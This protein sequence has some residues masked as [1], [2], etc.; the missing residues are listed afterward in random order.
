MLRAI[1]LI[2]FVTFHFTAT[3]QEKTIEYYSA[4]L[5]D[6]ADKCSNSNCQTVCS[7]A[8]SRVANLDDVFGNVDK[9]IDAQKNCYL[10]MMSSPKDMMNPQAVKL[11]S[12]STELQF[13]PPTAPSSQS[14]KQKNKT[15]TEVDLNFLDADGGVNI[16]KVN[17]LF[18]VLPEYCDMLHASSRELC[19][20]TCVEEA[21][22]FS[23][24]VASFSDENSD[25]RI[26]RKLKHG[27]YYNGCSTYFANDGLTQGQEF[28]VY[29]SLKSALNH[30]KDSSWPSKPNSEVVEPPQ[31]DIAKE[32][33]SPPSGSSKTV[34]F[35]GQVNIDFAQM[36]RGRQL[37]ALFNGNR[38][39]KGVLKGELYAHLAGYIQS[40]SR[41]CP[42]SLPENKIEINTRA[43]CA[44]ETT[45]SNMY[46]SYTRCTSY[47]NVGTGI[48][49]DPL[50]YWGYDIALE[51]KARQMMLSAASGTVDLA[52]KSTDINDAYEADYKKLITTYGCD[53]MVIAKEKLMSYMKQALP[54]Y[55]NIVYLDSIKDPLQKQ[56]ALLDIL[57]GGG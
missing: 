29:E 3:A 7:N 17:E 55:A 50:I 42:A 15:F 27:Y 12:E 10:A 28:E 35:S 56:Q 37:D 49:A 11:M 43:G 1:V 57:R 32:P 25:A 41:N 6:T 26:V 5:N 30:L 24:D 34:P 39:Q 23:D 48:Y 46:G 54:N 20:R 52:L 38:Q 4:L 19:Q 53:S 9:I 44:I 40:V 31:S 51:Q 2:S 36:K 14:A 47:H 22:K 18:T 8:A 45:T 33:V 16:R 21:K 13:R